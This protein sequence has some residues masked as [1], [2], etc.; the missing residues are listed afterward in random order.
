MATKDMPERKDGKDGKA[1]SAR[2]I[3]LDDLLPT[4]D[5][6]GGKQVFGGGRGGTTPPSKR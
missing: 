4:D 6:K 1:K 3:R 2:L 5:V